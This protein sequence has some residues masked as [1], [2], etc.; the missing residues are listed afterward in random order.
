MVMKS[1]TLPHTNVAPVGRY[2]EDHFALQRTP[3][4][5]HVGGRVTLHYGWDSWFGLVAWAFEPLLLVED[6]REPTP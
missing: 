6:A 2:L 3:V 5:C 1:D 4:R